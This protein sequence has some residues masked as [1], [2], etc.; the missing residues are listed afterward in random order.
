MIKYDAHMCHHETSNHVGETPIHSQNWLEHMLP[1]QY[2]I[3]MELT[4]LSIYTFAN[5]IECLLNE[6]PNIK[7]VHIYVSTRLDPRYSNQ[8][9][10]DEFYEY[11]DHYKDKIYFKYDNTVLSLV[12][13]KKM[14][15]SVFNNYLTQF[16]KFA[17]RDKDRDMYIEYNGEEYNA[18]WSPLNEYHEGFTWNDFKH[19]VTT[20]L[21]PQ[22]NCIK[23]FSN[24]LISIEHLKRG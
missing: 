22:N 17:W 10:I 7:V 6:Y 9:T 19:I 14:P 12:K 18:L 8:Q 24:T 4:L 3:T 5:H 21:K 11:I 1:M 20:N 15:K 23:Y 13:H 16:A 2:S